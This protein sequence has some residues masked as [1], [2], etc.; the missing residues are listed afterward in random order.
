CLNN[1]TLPE[2]ADD[3]RYPAT[4]LLGTSSVLQI[5]V[6]LNLAYF[7]FR[8]IRAPAF[9][10]Y[11]RAMTKT[12]NIIARALALYRSI[13]K[14]EKLDLFSE[15]TR[16]WNKGDVEAQKL[17]LHI[18]N[19]DRWRDPFDENMYKFDN[20]IRYAA[21]IVAALA[22]IF[23]VGSSAM[24]AC[25]IRIRYFLVI[26]AVCLTPTIM[27]IAYNLLMAQMAEKEIQTVAERGRVVEG[28]MELFVKAIPR[29]YLPDGVL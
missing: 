20:F 29:K 28:E 10:R 14:P 22:F 13:P 21:L 3:H 8:E 11:E 19:Q 17:N 16:A 18:W 23:L 4:P 1:P 27:A 26:T 5:S 12:D 2:K 25:P 6:A 15:E 9:L 24:A 7:S